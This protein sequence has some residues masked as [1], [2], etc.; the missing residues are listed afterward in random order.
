MVR[1]AVGLDAGRRLLASPIATIFVKCK[2]RRLSIGLLPEGDAGSPR[3]IRVLTEAC[4]GVSLLEGAAR[5][6]G[7]R[8]FSSVRNPSVRLKLLLDTS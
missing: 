6:H 8:R 4:P 5:G 3:E 1:G 2:P 7:H